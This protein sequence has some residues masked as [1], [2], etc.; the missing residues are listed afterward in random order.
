[1]GQLTRPSLLFTLILLA[2]VPLL[3]LNMFLP[4]LG[5]MATDFQVGYDEMAF[6]VS[7]YLAF[8]ALIQ[9]LTGPLADRLGRRPVLLVSLGVFTCASVGCALAQDYTTF[10]FFRV[11]QGAIATGAALSRAVV[12]DLVPGNQTTSMLAC[13][14]MAMRSAPIVAPAVGR[15]ICNAVGMRGNCWFY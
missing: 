9:I 12:N 5:V 10:L 14:S 15:S 7:G 3:S 11:L 13:I 4:S 6:A 1:M 8:T 2:A